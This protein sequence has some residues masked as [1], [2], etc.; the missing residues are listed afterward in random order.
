MG[1]FIDEDNLPIMIKW[2]GSQS[3]KYTASYCIWLCAAEALALSNC[4]AAHWLISRAPRLIRTHA[5]E[6]IHMVLF[7]LVCEQMLCHYESEFRL[8]HA[9]IQSLLY[10]DFSGR[11]NNIYPVCK[12]IYYVSIADFRGL[13]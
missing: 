11:T 4:C 5:K 2:L 7:S 3:H 9:S 13:G 1:H 8:F 6:Y 10:N 12:F